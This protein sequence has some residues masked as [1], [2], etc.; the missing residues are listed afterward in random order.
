MWW[1]LAALGCREPDAGGAVA[2]S[3]VEPAATA[4]R[5]V[6]VEVAGA[7]LRF[8]GVG[9][10]HR[11][12]FA[13]PTLVADLPASLAGC[14]P[15]PIGLA[16][17]WSDAEMAG[18]VQVEVEAGALRCA[19]RADGATLDV[20]A[21]AP[22]LKAVAAWR[23]RVAAGR[24]LRV[25]AFRTGVVVRG[26]AGEVAL[27]GAGRGETAGLAVEPCVD[28]DGGQVCAV[29]D[30]AGLRL[31]FAEPAAVSRLAGRLGGGR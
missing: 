27:W 5:L 30:A 9:A 2:P 29:G 22:M 21:L 20:T 25:A 13:D 19:A 4:P 10:L 16:V 24:D 17:R 26:A 31:V 6:V 18:S 15:G 11:K 14:V 23:D 3:V 28:L 12:F 7:Q 8:T 1:L